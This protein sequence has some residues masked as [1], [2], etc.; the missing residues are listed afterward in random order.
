MNNIVTPGTGLKP[1][2]KS[3]RK[4][5]NLS[6][7]VIAKRDDHGEV[8]IREIQKTRAQVQHIW[9]VPEDIPTEFDIV[10]CELVEDLPSRFKGMPDSAQVT[11]IVVIPASGTMNRKA[12]ENS[13]PHAVIHLPCR[14][15][16][17]LSAMIVALSHYQYTRRLR[18][19][20]EKA[21]ARVLLYQGSNGSFG[22]WGPGGNDLWLDAY[23][24]DFLGRARSQ[25]YNVPGTA[26]AQALDRLENGI[27]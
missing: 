14:A 1:A 9:P 21:I 22:L 12:L 26:F 27:A 17:V 18:Q 15:E 2:A 5:H 20:I 10:F 23:V 3:S 8:L 16:E 6:I 7:A 13:V 11:L 19:R 4:F 24:T 25:G